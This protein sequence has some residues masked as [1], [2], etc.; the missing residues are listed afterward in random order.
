METD[1]KLPATLAV[2]VQHRDAKAATGDVS[3]AA[4]YAELVAACSQVI[5]ERRELAVAVETGFAEQYVT[6]GEVTC[7]P[8]DD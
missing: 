4:W 5:A 6:V 2:A 3:M 1:E 8:D 7:E